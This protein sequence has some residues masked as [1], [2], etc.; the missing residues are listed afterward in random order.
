MGAQRTQCAHMCTRAC[1][2]TGSG[3]H[4]GRPT[5]PH[6]PGTS[7]GTTAAHP[8]ARMAPAPSIPPACASRACWLGSSGCCCRA[9]MSSP[10]E[11]LGP[12]ALDAA[13]VCAAVDAEGAAVACWRC[14]SVWRASSIIACMQAMA[15]RITRAFSASRS[16]RHCTTGGGEAGAAVCWLIVDRTTR[17]SPAKACDQQVMVL[18]VV[19]QRGAKCNKVSVDR[20]SPHSPC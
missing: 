13:C 1:M 18:T 10:A 2:C 4:D 20:C 5:P 6:W 17:D 12:P 11:R 19:E 3:G 9:G 14:W 8:A 7:A 16:A 15:C